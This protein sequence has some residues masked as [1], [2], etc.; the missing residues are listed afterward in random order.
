MHTYQVKP[1]EIIGP[2]ADN[3]TILHYIAESN[4]ADSMSLAIEYI[5]QLQPKQ[6]SKAFNIQDCHGNTPA[7]ICC[8][9]D[10]VET[11]EIIVKSGLADLNVKNSRDQTAYDVA[12]ENDSPCVNLLKPK[13][14]SQTRDSPINLTPSPM[15]SQ[16]PHVPKNLSPLSPKNAKFIEPPS[17]ARSSFQLRS[18]NSLKKEAKLNPDTRLYQV[19]TELT[20]Q[21]INF[22]DEEF[23]HD[24]EGVTNGDYDAE[25]TQKYGEIKW[26]RASEC[27]PNANTTS[28]GVFEGIDIPDV[29]NSPLAGCDLYSALAIM[30]EYP[31][32]LLKAFSTKD[33]NQQGAYSINFLVSGIPLEILVDDYFPCLASNKKPLF[34]SP[35]NNEIWFML[36]EKAFAKL[37][38]NY[39]EI[40]SIQIDE[41]LEMLTNMP[42]SLTSLKGA[43]ADQLW[44]IM[45]EN[46]KRNYISC[47][48]KNSTQDSKDNRI[49]SISRLCESDS[50]RIIKIKD[51]YGSFTW[52]GRF[53]EGSEHWTKEVKEEVGHYAGEKNCFYMEIK[54]FIKHFDYVTV[55]YYNESWI[56]NSKEAA[57]RPN[58]AAF[59]EINLER[60]MDV[61]ISVHQKLPRFV[62]EED[63]SYNISPVEILVAE[64]LDGGVLRRVAKG[65]K[66][67][68]LGKQTVFADDKVKIKLSEG[69]YIIRTKIRWLDNSEHDFTL[70][71]LSPYPLTLSRVKSRAHPKFLERVYLE[72]GNSASDRYQ[73]GN[74]CEFGS[75]WCGS[76]LWLYGVNKGSKTW[77]L[78]IVFN[79]NENLRLCKKYRTEENVI[80]LVIPPN[81][82]AVAY[83]KKIAQT[84]VELNWKFNQSWS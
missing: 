11:L 68:F 33:A 69:R 70:N 14:L 37:Y 19:I 72:A 53:S 7:I 63:S 39:N 36:A 17:S 75:S 4:F 59:F 34:S 38:G 40:K 35:L 84:D 15:A 32:R 12:Y 20:E 9:F 41:A 5:Q 56:R 28:V 71:T 46:D 76:H 24:G 82:R 8:I 30:T 48:G 54:E 64:E 13:N 45:L 23:P 18:V 6:A 66:D 1:T 10:S 58:K 60:E 81:G 42:T 26:L 49:F 51:H 65:E 43:N 16:S 50:Y 55:C 77:N 47:A 57:S 29:K 22:A 2:Q 67:A 44:N 27:L 21:N 80:K 79:K 62:G 83:V 52:N 61:I 25:I 3:K 31:Q 74:R 73:L 78:E